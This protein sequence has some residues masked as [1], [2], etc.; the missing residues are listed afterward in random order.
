MS[1]KQFADLEAKIQAEKAFQQE[2]IKRRKEVAAKIKK[3]INWLVGENI[4]ERK[5]LEVNK[6]FPQMRC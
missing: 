1:K 6:K 3:Q 2:E 5:S 4:K